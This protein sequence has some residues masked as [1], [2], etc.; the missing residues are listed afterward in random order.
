MNQTNSTYIDNLTYCK[1]WTKKDSEVATSIKQA[2]L[3]FVGIYGIM[4]NL[5]VITLAVKYT[6]RKN[7]HHMIIGMA[8]SDSLLILMQ[9][10]FYIQRLSDFT[11]TLFPEGVAGVFLCKVTAFLYNVSYS[12]S[13]LSLMIISVERYRATGITLKRSRPYTMKQRMITVG[14][15]W[16]IPMA[17]FAN[18]LYHA[19]IVEQI[20]G[21]FL[22]K[23][24]LNVPEWFFLIQPVLIIVSFI[25]IFTL[26]ILTI[27]RLSKPHAGIRASLNER[28]RIK[29]TQRVRATIRMVLSS[30]L[31]YTVCWLPYYIYSLLL[32]L[33]KLLAKYDVTV[34]D[35]TICVDL[36]SFSFLAF[37]FLPLVNSSFSPCM[38]LIFLTDFRKGMM[39]FL[40]RKN[41]NGHSKTLKNT[42]RPRAGTN[43]TSLF[44]IS[45]DSKVSEKKERNSNEIKTGYHV[46]TNV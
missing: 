18:T 5:F 23:N 20:P 36:P 19:T 26:S 42:Q 35:L 21:V 25:V 30:L 4:A 22:C 1:L 9:P 40:G 24:I 27:L 45:S 3:G 10:F 31:L 2:A 6:V 15:S 28:H 44:N 43:G 17:L 7:L 39:I 41:A 33:H 37:Y 32:V 12:Q 34:I 11:L 29:R 16:F 38:Y 14:C 8:V 13:L 46:D